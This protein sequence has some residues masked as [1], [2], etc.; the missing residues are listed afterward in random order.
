MAS[1]PPRQDEG[2]LEDTTQLAQKEQRDSRSDEK[3]C[4]E[5]D[6]AGSAGVIKAPRRFEPEH[7]ETTAFRRSAASGGTVLTDT[8]NHRSG[9][10]SKVKD[11]LSTEVGTI[12]NPRPRRN[13][14]PQ[15]LETAA[16]C[17]R[18]GKPLSPRYASGDLSDQD[19]A[20]PSP[21]SRRR[22][23]IG[24]RSPSPSGSSQA[25]R[26]DARRLASPLL[27]RQSS[28][29]STRSH[30]YQVPH[31][32]TIESSGSEEE[33]TSQHASLSSTPPTPGSSRNSYNHAA[34]FRESTH[35]NSSDYLLRLAARAAEQQ[36]REQAMAAFPNDDHHEPVAHF[37]N[38]DV[39]SAFPSRQPTHDSTKRYKY[40]RDSSEANW[41]IRGL[42]KSW[43]S[44]KRNDK[45]KVTSD[46]S[47]HDGRPLS[48]LA[49]AE[50]VNGIV[51]TG[52]T[53]DLEIGPMRNGARPPML[54]DDILFPRCPSPEQARFDVTQGSYSARQSVCHLAVQPEPD[55]E[56]LWRNKSEAQLAPPPASPS[57]WSGGNALTKT[58]SH[59]TSTTSGLWAGSCTSRDARPNRCSGIVT[60]HVIDE[61]SLL[62]SDHLLQDPHQQLPPSPPSSFPGTTSLDE[63]LEQARRID[64]E[65][66][67]DFVTQVYN[68]LSLGYPAIARNF[69]MELSKITRIP[70][71]ELRQD[72]HLAGSCGYFRLGEDFCSDGV[73]I[74]QESCARWR[75][76]QMYVRE[77]ARQN[78]ETLQPFVEPRDGGFGVGVRRGSWAW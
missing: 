75:A 26:S 67:R 15:L 46:S 50:A 77:W 5:Q 21:R 31:L 24:S 14:T 38:R 54:G 2:H 35:E 70:I 78:P 8:T 64:T 22:F 19:P 55:R 18:V 51:A 29:G 68:Y 63:K 40:R 33:V 16:R 45:R 17:R 73:P 52:V 32:R 41:L 37:I 53:D 57:M 43:R 10:E 39:G 4:G 65:F 6:S 20:C 27:S 7:L 56:G 47:D 66:D 12:A 9:V 60:P 30:S 72:D 23:E 61:D 59:P 74:T 71:E 3:S 25:E 76:L 36:L 13:F 1:I 44:R 69:D 49:N 48:R 58:I 28:F 42:R 11:S 62:D 34:R